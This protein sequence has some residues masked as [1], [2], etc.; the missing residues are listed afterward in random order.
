MGYRQRRATSAIRSRSFRAFA[1]TSTTK[2]SLSGPLSSPR[3]AMRPPATHPGRHGD[4]PPPRHA[5]VGAPASKMADEG[6]GTSWD[7]DCKSGPER[8]P[9]AEIVRDAG[10]GKSL[11]QRGD[12]DRA[13]A[14][15]EQPGEKARNGART[16]KRSRERQDVPGHALSSVT[17]RPGRGAVS[18]V[19]GLMNS[20]RR[21]WASSGDIALKR[22]L[23]KGRSWAKRPR[24]GLMIVP[25][26]G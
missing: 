13:A 24:S 3:L 19:H 2:I 5:G 15:T 26:F 20:R 10:I 22:T 4:N 18:R 9:H 17:P 21:I 6:R 7:H 8:H 16:C 11:G 12:D 25:N 23:L 14:N 1:S